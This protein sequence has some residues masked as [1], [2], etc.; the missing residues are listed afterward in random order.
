MKKPLERKGL[1]RGLSALMGEAGLNDPAREAPEPEAPSN[2]GL[3]DIPIDLL[4][5]NPDQPRRHFAEDELFQ[6]IRSIKAKGVLQPLIVRPDPFQTGAFQIVAGERRWRA[7]QRA[8][9]HSLPAIIRDFD[10]TEML[11][12]ALV[13]NIQRAELNPIEEAAAYRQ[14]MDQFG[15][16]QEAVAAALGKSRSHIANLVRLL[17]LPEEVLTL[18]RNGKLSAGHARALV[19]MADPIP[20]AREAV[21]KG[22]T[23]RQVEE[24]ARRFEG[25]ATRGKTRRRPEKDPDT[26][27][28]ERA[29][30][31]QTGLGVTIDPAK[32]AEGGHIRLTYRSLDQLDR[33]VRILSEAWPEADI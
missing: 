7:A 15:H 6:L 10:D 31:A 19:P 16:T 33:L 24:R 28:L 25:P 32:G 11:E 23:V 18:L 26:R 12:V 13:E 29:I 14:L 4:A 17:T 8:G 30:A 27:E 2:V 20:L 1:G 21:A 5:P 3:T 22:L 9:L